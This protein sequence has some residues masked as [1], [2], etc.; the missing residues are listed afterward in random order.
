MNDFYLS[1][2][3]KAQGLWVRLKSHLEDR[4]AVA[5]QRNDAVQPESDTA[6]LRGEIRCLKRLLS[7][8][9]DRPMTGDD[10]QPL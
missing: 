3:D 2:Q 8:G 4:L 1:E 6:A 5:R 9:D 7:L 10:L